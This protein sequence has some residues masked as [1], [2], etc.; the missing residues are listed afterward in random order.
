MQR[1]QSAGPMNNTIHSSVNHNTNNN[2]KNPSNHPG[3]NSSTA[4]QNNGSSPKRTGQASGRSSMSP[5]ACGARARVLLMITTIN[6]IYTYV[7]ICVCTY[8]YT[9]IHIYTHI[10][11]IHICPAEQVTTG[12]RAPD[13]PPRRAQD[14]HVCHGLH[15]LSPLCSG[16]RAAL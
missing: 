16:S 4:N 11:I 10:P 12:L 1:S 6:K 7:Y 3:S 2:T 15:G 13:P 8:I 9:Y 5:T 14:Q